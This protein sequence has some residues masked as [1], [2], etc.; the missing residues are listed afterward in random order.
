[1]KAFMNLRAA[2]ISRVWRGESATPEQIRKI[3]E[4]INAAAKAIDE[5]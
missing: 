4:A 1:M 5:L 2:V 3:A